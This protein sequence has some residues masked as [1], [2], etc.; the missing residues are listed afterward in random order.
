MP[1][2]A[3]G[4]PDVP[5][6]Q[7]SSESA[8][9]A[10]SLVLIQFFADLAP[11]SDLLP[12]DALGKARVRFFLD[13]VSNKIQPG[14]SKWTLGLGSYDAFFE[15]LDAIQGQLPPAGEGKYIFGDKFT[16]GDI[17]IAPFLGRVLLVQLKNGIG[18]FDKEEAKRGWERFQGPKYERVRQYI[19]DIAARPSWQSTFDEVRGTTYAELAHFLVCFLS[20]G[21]PHQGYHRTLC[22]SGCRV[23]D[24]VA[25]V[26]TEIVI[27]VGVTSTFCLFV[28]EMLSGSHVILS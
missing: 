9:I 13:T 7:P 15:A 27:H 3:Y 26:V 4:G 11:E 22:V 5:P 17:A 14:L 8:K 23:C 12:Q 21:L 28:Y 6:D 1:A 10:E 20:L 25:E 18:K 16:L 2:V 24:R 19:D